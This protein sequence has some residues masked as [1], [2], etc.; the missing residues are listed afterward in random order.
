ME[1]DDIVIE[2]RT[3]V[4]KE[5]QEEDFLE[6][7]SPHFARN[8]KQAL[9]P[10]SIMKQKPEQKA[11]VEIPELDDFTENLFKRVSGDFNVEGKTIRE[12]TFGDYDYSPTKKSI[13]SPIQKESNNLPGP[14]KLESNFKGVDE[15]EEQQLLNSVRNKTTMQLPL[16]PLSKIRKGTSEEKEALN[17]Y[18][19]PYEENKFVLNE[20][21]GI[22]LTSE[23]D[24]LIPKH[25]QLT[26]N[27]PTLMWEVPPYKL[28]LKYIPTEL[29]SEDPIELSQTSKKDVT[30]TI[31]TER[32][33]KLSIKTAKRKP[34][35]ASKKESKENESIK[36]DDANSVEM[37]SQ[38]LTARTPLKENSELN[39]QY[40]TSVKDVPDEKH[41]WVSKTNRPES[42]LFIPSLL[43]EMKASMDPN[44][45]SAMPW[46]GQEV[47]PGCNPY[48]AVWMTDYLSE[49]R[50]WKKG[51][52]GLLAKIQHFVKVVMMSEL[53]GAFMILC[54][55][56]NTT[57]LAMNRYG[58]P[59]DEASIVQALNTVFTSIFIAEM[60][61]KLFSLGIV[62]YL[63]DKL[64]YVDGGA[65]VLSIIELIFLD[66]SKNN[67]ALTAF[68]AFRMLR[69]LRVVRMVRL[70]RSLRSMQLLIQVIGETLTS[71]AYIGMLLIVFL[72]IYSL[73]GMQL[74]GGMFDFPDGKPRQNYD[75]FH[76]A[77]LSVYQ[78]LTIENWQSLQ[79][80]SMRAQVPTLVALFYVT[81]L[82]IGNYVLLNLFLALMLDAFAEVEDENSREEESTVHFK[83]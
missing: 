4:P 21:V 82:F 44:K 28:K 18:N 40:A 8:F 27:V 6:K 48:L 10:G 81:W 1:E 52:K 3:V 50:V 23:K 34:S 46:S 58:Q 71:F 36:A 75:S 53:M 32:K 2:R 60:A 63:S 5:K 47:L 9:Q 24:V 78:V 66:S 22:A 61:L 38:N 74:F 56:I 14:L 45:K 68:Q 57:V 17:E 16:Y 80:S 35:Q 19:E 76:K 39:S 59:A 69:A 12:P 73:L 33:Q 54:V 26:L 25:R 55:L 37:K 15:E 42:L 64:N 7:A 41:K 83:N 62:K 13:S 70:L 29:P 49:V 20:E 65:V 79:Y 51:P 43:E 72:F 77:F 67:S 31:N 30:Q 11:G